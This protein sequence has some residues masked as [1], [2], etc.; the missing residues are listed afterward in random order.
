MEHVGIENWEKYGNLMGHVKNI[1]K[2]KWDGVIHMPLVDG[3][4]KRFD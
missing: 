2:E 4:L 3:I 1:L